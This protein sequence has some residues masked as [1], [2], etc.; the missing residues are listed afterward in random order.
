[1]RSFNIWA[2]TIIVHCNGWVVPLSQPFQ[3]VI[4]NGA[5][6]KNEVLLAAVEFRDVDE[7]VPILVHPFVNQPA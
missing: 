4:L 3:V 1:M 5:N 6:G 7:I 2:L